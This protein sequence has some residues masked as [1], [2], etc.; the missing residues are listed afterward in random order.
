MHRNG[1]TTR[2]MRERIGPLFLRMQTQV[3]CNSFARDWQTKHKELQRQHGKQ[4][5]RPWKRRRQADATAATP[6]TSATQPVAGPSHGAPAPTAPAEQPIA[7]P[8]DASEDISQ[9]PVVVEHD[10]L[11]DDLSIPD[12]V[13][14]GDTE[15]ETDYT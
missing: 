3:V 15:M 10:D 13:I 9:A 5:T 8:S 2:L 1:A 4:C 7:G 12:N 14:L 6:E 11:F